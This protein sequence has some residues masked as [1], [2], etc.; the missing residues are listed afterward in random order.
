MKKR[1]IVL[2][3]SGVETKIDPAKWI[4]VE[5]VKEYDAT[6]TAIL[7]VFQKDDNFLVYGMKATDV[8]GEPTTKVEAYDLAVDVGSV[9]AFVAKVAK[10]CGVEN[11][12]AR[13]VKSR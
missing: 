11:L 2:L 8:V 12:V 10:N 1:T 5:G 13:L 7:R 4:Q 3:S 9:P 6:S